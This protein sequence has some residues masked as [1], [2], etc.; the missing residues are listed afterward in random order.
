MVQDVSPNDT[1]NTKWN[2]AVN[3]S[4]PGVLFFLK[5]LNASKSSTQGSS[6]SKIFSAQKITSYY[7]LH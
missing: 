4:F 6:L 5:D 1:E 2:W 7:L 3:P